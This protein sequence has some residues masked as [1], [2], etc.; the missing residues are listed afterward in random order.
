M[1]NILT[2]AA[3]GALLAGI[4][5]AY[6]ADMPVK[7]PPAPVVAAFNWG[8]FYIG[9]NAG[10]SW[11]QVDLVP[12]DPAI[13]INQVSG[14]FIPGRGIVIV[15][16]TTRDRPPLSADVSGFVGGGQVGFN[17]QSG[18]WVYGV[19]GDVQATTGARSAAFT[20]VL[21]FTALSA[22]SPVTTARNFET[23]L[24]ASLRLRAGFAVW[25]RFL[26]YGTGG[27]A[28]ARG[29]LTATD[30][31]TITPGPGA[32]PQSSDVGPQLGGYPFSIG[33]ATDTQTHVGWTLGVGGD[34]A[35]T[36][37][38]IVGVLYRHS[39]LGTKTYNVGTQGFGGINGPIATPAVSSVGLTTSGDSVKLTDDQVTARVSWR[40]GT[41]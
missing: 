15:P 37:N 8:G 6:A 26:V 23:E 22:P 13:R 24:M 33:R 27:L 18:R 36:D 17:I 39:D 14:V 5:T 21:P 34:W 20:V 38:I 32:P 30:T 1:R 10:G 16:G 11:R 9:G 35:V 19:E 41:R 4:S 7:A 40:F 3:V 12:V 31:F 2:S 25:D 29:K 28:I